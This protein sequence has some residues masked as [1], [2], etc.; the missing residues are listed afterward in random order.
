MRTIELELS[1]GRVI[2]VDL[3]DAPKTEA[4]PASSIQSQKS[5]GIDIG[6]ALREG[7]KSVMLPSQQQM[8][9]G[10][11]IAQRFGQATLG[12]IYGQGRQAIQEMVPQQAQQTLG[13]AMVPFSGILP[14]QA[15]QAI[16]REGVGL[17]TDIGSGL[18]TSGALKAGSVAIRPFKGMLQSVKFGGAKD[19][20]MLAENIRK[21]MGTVD[22]TFRADYDTIM[23]NSGAKV[24]PEE[25]RNQIIQKLRGSIK[26]GVDEKYIATM[27]KEFD[28]PQLTVQDLHNMKPDLYAA[29]KSQRGG[30]R[31]GLGE[32]YGEVNTV[33][34][35]KSMAGTMYDSVSKRYDFYKK[36]VERYMNKLTLD[37]EKKVSE[38]PL[39]AKKKLTLNQQ[40]AIRALSNLAKSKDLTPEV[41]AMIRGG[42]LK[43]VLELYGP[44]AIAGGL[45]VG[46][47]G[48]T[49][50]WALGKLLR[51]S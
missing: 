6:G 23:K 32:V 45:A 26:K 3:E 42:N 9:G 51:D 47:G 36:E 21:D 13:R 15:Q 40:E 25:L 44:R 22:S 17:L 19:Y 5:T 49:G 27:E 24:V 2:E 29:M 11:D 38:A 28:N 43:K 34:K 20:R 18:A 16:G 10:M 35:D 14:S 7:A 1:D 8:A 50:A 4:T 33:L 31:S 46:A 41:Q 48:I 12:S 39:Q 37:V 30:A